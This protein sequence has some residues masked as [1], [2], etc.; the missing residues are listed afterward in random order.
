M[1]RAERGEARS[2]LARKGCSKLGPCILRLTQVTSL[3]ANPSAVLW[4][5]KP[6]IYFPTRRDWLSP[7]DTITIPV[8]ISLFPFR[9]FPKALLIFLLILRGVVQFI[10]FTTRRTIFGNANNKFDQFFFFFGNVN[11]NR[12]E[13]VV[14]DSAL[15][16]ASWISFERISKS[17]TNFCTRR[18]ERGCVQRYRI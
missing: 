17:R 3:E 16:V 15:S 11:D 5:G 9:K 1:D 4:N 6:Q 13:L 7:R 8:S 10:F 2:K 18:K 14:I 12:N